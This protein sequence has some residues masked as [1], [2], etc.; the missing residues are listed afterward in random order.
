LLLFVGRSADRRSGPNDSEPEA[1]AWPRRSPATHRRRCGRRSGALWGRARDGPDRRHGRAGAGGSC[2][3]GAIQTRGGPR[4]AF[5]E[6]RDPQLAPGP[7]RTLTLPRP[8][9]T[10][11]RFQQEEATD[12]RREAEHGSRH[13]GSSDPVRPRTGH[14]LERRRRV[15]GEAAH[16]VESRM[17]CSSCAR[18]V[19]GIRPGR[20]VFRRGCPDLTHGSSTKLVL[21]RIGDRPRR[22]RVHPVFAAQT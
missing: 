15:V 17:V 6:K 20:K 9:L 12:R 19:V 16:V 22:C 21:G 11:S 1:Q 10:K 18:E 3:C 8:P 5:A 7:H 13:A 4:S 14:V 2:R